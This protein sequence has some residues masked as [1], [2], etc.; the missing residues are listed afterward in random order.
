MNEIE[1]G[2]IVTKKKE[3][4]TKQSIYLDCKLIIPYALPYSLNDIVM[5]TKRDKELHYYVC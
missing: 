1:K 5:K 2:Q 4:R 3:K